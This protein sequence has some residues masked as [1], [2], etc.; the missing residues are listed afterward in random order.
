M[1]AKPVIHNNKRLLTFYR[2]E[3]VYNQPIKNI[4]DF[5]LSLKIDTLLYKFGN[6]VE[7]QK[8]SSQYE[9]T[10]IEY[11][12]SS[13]WSGINNRCK[14]TKLNSK[15]W[16]LETNSTTKSVNSQS[17]S[18]IFSLIEYMNV[19]NLFDM[20]M[21]ARTDASTVYMKIYFKDGTVKE[22]EDYGMEG[23]FSL[24]LLY[25]LFSKL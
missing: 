22:I 18:S 12:C 20:Y 2:I 8:S 5:K 9:I 1:L 4:F 15:E 10:E 21:V 14:L 6:F 19:K 16:Q 24:R 7:Y 13:S 23:T 17:M 25:E 3:N 11:Q